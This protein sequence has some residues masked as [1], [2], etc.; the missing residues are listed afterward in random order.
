MEDF[1]K[2]WDFKDS[3]KM[4]YIWWDCKVTEDDKK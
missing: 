3:D 2:P 1:R 4:P